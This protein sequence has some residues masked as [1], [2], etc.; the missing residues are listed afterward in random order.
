MNLYESTANFLDN[1]HRAYRRTDGGFSVAAQIGDLPAELGLTIDADG[2]LTVTAA[3]P[4][5]AQPKYTEEVI[6]AVNTAN[7]FANF[8]GFAL[9]PEDDVVRF[10]SYVRLRGDVENELKYLIESTD[11]ALNK[12]GPSLIAVC[13]GRMTA[14]EYLSEWN[15]KI[16]E[17]SA[18]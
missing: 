18:Q 8:G 3:L 5:E 16:K 2:T 6:G 9:Y 11:K 15:K 13:E 12:F 10:R 1:T 14:A 4:A 17:K 7:A